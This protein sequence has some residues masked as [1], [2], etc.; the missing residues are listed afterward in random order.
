MAAPIGPN[1][2]V[3]IHIPKFPSDLSTSSNPVI[4]PVARAAEKV[5]PAAPVAPQAPGFFRKLGNAAWWMVKT[6][7]VYVATSRPVLGSLVSIVKTGI[8]NTFLNEPVSAVH[9]SETQQLRKLGQAGTDVEE[10]SSHLSSTIMSQVK[11]QVHPTLLAVFNQQ[12][13][14]VKDLIETI[15]MKMFGNVGE[16][17]CGQNPKELK[18][19]INLVNVMAHIMADVNKSLTDKVQADLAK[20][21]AIQDPKLR[22]QAVQK[23]IEPVLDSVLR[24]ML[25]NGEKEL[26]LAQKGWVASAI[27]YKLGESLPV[28]AMK[29]VK[30]LLSS[31]LVKYADA[32]RQ[33][34]GAQVPDEWRNKPENVFL[35]GTVKQ[36][37]GILGEIRKAVLADPSVKQGLADFLIDKIVPQPKG[38]GFSDVEMSNRIYLKFH[39][40]TL[41]TTVN[42]DNPEVIALWNSLDVGIHQ[43]I[44]K[45]LMNLA[46]T[47]QTTG[48]ATSDI[49]MNVRDI[50]SSYS[51]RIEEIKTATRSD[52]FR[53]TS[54]R[55]AEKKTYEF[56]PDMYERHYK[57]IFAEMAQVLQERLGLSGQ[58]H[59]LPEAIQEKVNTFVTET[60]SRQLAE[61]YQIIHGLAEVSQ[62]IDQPVP[63]DNLQRLL[64]PVDGQPVH[65][66]HD[67][68]KTGGPILTDIIKSFLYLENPSNPFLGGL[69]ADAVSSN[70]PS[71]AKMLASNIPGV[72]AEKIST[73]MSNTLTDQ[74]FNLSQWVSTWVTKNLY[75]L[76]TSSDPRASKVWEFLGHR[77]DNIV[78]NIMDNVKAHREEFGIPEGEV[79][80]NLPLAFANKLVGDLSKFFVDHPELKTEYERLKQEQATARTTLLSELKYASFA[81]F[82]TKYRPQIM[83]YPEMAKRYAELEQT[84]RIIPTE[85]ASFVTKFGPK[86][87]VDNPAI[88]IEFDRLRLA[89]EAEPYNDPNLIKQFQPIATQLFRDMGIVKG[90]STGFPSLI[91]SF[92]ENFLETGSAPFSMPPLLC[93]FACS[94]MDLE[95][96]TPEYNQRLA[97][98]VPPDQAAKIIDKLDSLIGPLID[99]GET[100][101]GPLAASFL[102]PAIDVKNPDAIASLVDPEAVAAR[103]P[104]LQGLVKSVILQMLV[105]YLEGEK[106]AKGDLSLN[107][108]V[109]R[110]VGVLDRYLNP[111]MKEKFREVVAFDDITLESINK[112]PEPKKSRELAARDVEIAR[113]ERI[114]GNA[115]PSLADFHPS[116]NP[117]FANPQFMEKAVAERNKAIETKDGALKA[118]FIPLTKELI[119]LVRGDQKSGLPL[120]LPKTSLLYGMSDQAWSNNVEGGLSQMLATYF[121]RFL[122]SDDPANTSVASFIGAKTDQAEKLSRTS[123]EVT[124]ASE[125]VSK[126]ISNYIVGMVPDLVDTPDNVELINK[127]I[128]ANL[129]SLPEKSRNAVI[130]LL[131]GGEA[132]ETIKAAIAR[133][134]YSATAHDGKLLNFAQPEIESTIKVVTSS[135]ISYLSE[136]EEVAGQE[137]G[138]PKGD[139]GDAFLV[140]ASTQLIDGFAGQLKVLNDA[141][142]A[143]N[144]TLHE[145]TE[146][147]RLK[148]E[149]RL[150]NQLGMTEKVPV[151]KTVTGPDGEVVS[152]PVIINGVPQTKEIQ[153]VRKEIRTLKDQKS[154]SVKRLEELTHASE[155]R[156]LEERLNVFEQ[157]YE[158]AVIDGRPWLAKKYLKETSELKKKID[159]LKSKSAENLA[160]IAHAQEILQCK[161]T[162][163]QVNVQL[164]DLEEGLIARRSEFFKPMIKQVLA[165]IGITKKEDLPCPEEFRDQAWELL[166]KKISPE[167]LSQICQQFLD[168]EVL[169]GMVYDLLK[170]LETVDDPSIFLPKEAAQVKEGQSKPEYDASQAQLDSA[171]GSLILEVGRLVPGSFTRLATGLGPLRNLGARQV[172]SYFRGVINQEPSPQYN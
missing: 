117:A 168:P 128:H 12:E 36:S 25:P 145:L 170:P 76:G 146:D 35:S 150:I 33:F 96:T 69:A 55:G 4:D 64:T 42:S 88:K 20:A 73:D 23:A 84:Q 89:L 83:Q 50:L 22:E 2:K 133:T 114:L 140:Q 132:G 134:L 160:T 45:A 24:M 98:L 1:D 57:A 137:A 100:M 126:V 63:A 144:K 21:E 38:R 141:A 14:F 87:F 99:D 109:D 153:E 39:L 27:E 92:V 148:A 60:L 46:V 93:R 58:D 104:L 68:L 139:P 53:E 31:Q 112:M 40:E 151:I 28:L 143:Q 62:A 41:M 18:Y 11:Q 169:H 113:R 161:N 34:K 78:G 70:V 95:Y 66:F 124:G 81:D 165:L 47:G 102:A 101:V 106:D 120:D 149:K 162:I 147:E 136:L 29:Q 51:S 122:I 82:V 59:Q 103:K 13:G 16:H 116:K 163:K 37:I 79:N 155:I 61:N 5:L 131:G 85:F 49:V 9:Q 97:K 130:Q 166:N 26:G 32:T 94:F 90:E 74:T 115:I 10:F 157:K 17:M 71:L 159:D 158:N 52:L 75:A 125:R 44:E 8:Q 152:Q 167:M 156:G 86:F 127:S 142:S 77:L 118:L 105:H 164:K 3:N 91:D 119:G 108:A 121:H 171:F 111:E 56:V 172:G 65:Q 7:T 15:L 110:L 30:L 48:E 54:P 19:P 123:A 129:E 80:P 43:V 138:R 154:V 135:V 107:A 67:I 72:D 6:P